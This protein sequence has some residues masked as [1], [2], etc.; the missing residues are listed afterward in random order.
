LFEQQC[1]K[2]KQKY[3]AKFLDAFAGSSLN[4]SRTK[5]RFSC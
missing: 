1:W 3:D 2:L 4:I 5:K